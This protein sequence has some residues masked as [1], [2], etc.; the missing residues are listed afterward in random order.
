MQTAFVDRGDGSQAQSSYNHMSQEIAQLVIEILRLI[1]LNK[2]D[3]I[4][5]GVLLEGDRP[6]ELPIAP[7]EGEIIDATVIEFLPTPAK[8][9]LSAS[10]DELSIGVPQ[11]PPPPLNQTETAEQLIAGTVDR[12]TQHYALKQV[13]QSETYRFEQE[14]DRFI[15]LDPRD[16][17]IL[18]FEK[19]GNDDYE[20]T[21]NRMSIGQMQE[22]LQVRYHIEDQGLDRITSNFKTQTQSLGNLAPEGT[23]AAF[24]A[25]YLLQGYQTDTAQFQT[26]QFNQDSQGN[27]SITHTGTPTTYDLTQN[28]SGP[29][30]LRTSEGAIVEANLTESD[31]H[32]FSEVSRY[33]QAHPIAVER[34][35]AGVEIDS[36][37]GI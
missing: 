20:I 2:Q 24:V 7:I 1:E 11:L 17:E 12:L 31:K 14:D 8:Y 5:Q 15:V 25:D 33:A 9:Q 23:Q 10:D 16:R 26:Y 32:G 34:G 29:A 6:S 30:V 35:R 4:L 13:Y 36:R 21:H 3:R 19:L 22:F 37:S 28:P 27:L 18:A